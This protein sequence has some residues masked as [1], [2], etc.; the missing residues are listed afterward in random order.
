MTQHMTYFLQER[1]KKMLLVY[2]PPITLLLIFQW[3]TGVYKGPV[4]IY[5]EGG[6]EG[7]KKRA[8]QAYFRWARGGRLNV[9]VKKFEG[10]SSLIVRFIFQISKYYLFSLFQSYDSPLSLNCSP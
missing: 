8:D 6:A 10:V 9:F 2:L 1:A 3:H 4:I 7:K 5:V